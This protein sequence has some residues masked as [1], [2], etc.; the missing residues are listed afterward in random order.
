MIV[1]F[2]D[3]KCGLCQR[4]IR[5][6]YK[7]DKKKVLFFAPLNGITYEQIY[8]EKNTSLSSVKLY[9]NNKTYEKSLAFIKIGQLL[10][11]INKVSSLFIIIPSFIR[12]FLYDQIAARRKSVACILLIKNDRFLN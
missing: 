2:Y 6:L 12:D 7:A 10:G 3:N 11:G 9:Y 8:G 1:V 5:F 4:S